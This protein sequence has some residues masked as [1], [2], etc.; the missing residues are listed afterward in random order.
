MAIGARPGADVTSG[1]KREAYYR[2]ELW[3]HT[4]NDVRPTWV[5]EQIFTPVKG[6]MF[7]QNA[8]KNVDKCYYKLQ[9]ILWSLAQ[10]R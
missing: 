5:C 2:S 6:V 10:P 8:H 7:E 9:G 3:V 4:D 1:F